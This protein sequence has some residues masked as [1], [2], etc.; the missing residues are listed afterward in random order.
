MATVIDTIFHYND[1]FTRPAHCRVRVYDNTGRIVVI[2][3]ESPNNPGCSITN[4]A[5]QLATLVC[6]R[7]GLNAERIVWIEHY[8]ERRVKRSLRD[9]TFEEHF[10]LVTFRL[11]GEGFS[12][13]QWTAIDRSRVEQLIG[14]HF[15]GDEL[16]ASV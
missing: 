10:N 15:L 1:L 12:S 7:Y 13:P 4:S 14:Q 6:Q 9:D 5:D 11:S 2:A 8:P 3:S 16:P